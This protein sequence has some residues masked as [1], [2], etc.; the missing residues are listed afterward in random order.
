MNRRE[1]IKTGALASLSSSAIAA[2]EKPN[3]VLILATIQ[4]KKTY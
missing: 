1:F 2:A 4:N 3:I